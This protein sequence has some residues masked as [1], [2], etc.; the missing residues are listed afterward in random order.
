MQES[1]ALIRRRAQRGDAGHW[2]TCARQAHGKK[3]ISSQ[4]RVRT[5]SGPKDPRLVTLFV[6]LLWRCAGTRFAECPVRTEDA[7]EEAWQAM[8]GPLEMQGSL[9]C[10]TPTSVTPTLGTPTS[11]APTWVAWQGLRSASQKGP[12]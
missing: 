12:S 11:V 10:G 1:R 9:T 3:P 8:Q 5:G 2:G 4:S 6:K 7:R